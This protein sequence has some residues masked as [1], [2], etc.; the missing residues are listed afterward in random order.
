M[1]FTYS[2]R[3]MSLPLRRPP[4]ETG[5]VRDPARSKEISDET[6]LVFAKDHPGPGADVVVLIPAFNEEDAVADVVKSVPDTICGLSVETVVVDDGSRDNTTAEAEGAGALVCRLPINLGQ[7]TA[8]R[9][10]YRVSRER[11]ARF[12]CTA[13]ADGQFDPQELPA[14]VGPILA[15]QADFVNGS[16]KLGMTHNTDPV[17]NL[18]VVVFANLL[19]VLTGTKI[20]DP[21]NGLRAMRS[22]VTAKVQL[23]QTQYQTSEMLI[24]VIAHG[25]TVKEVPATMYKRAAGESKKGGNLIYGLRFARVVLTTWWKLRPVAKQ[26]LPAHQ[27]LW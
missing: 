1:A 2:F 18:G 27:G 13:D 11:G 12:I 5:A 17:R 25:F 23:K 6:A 4:L 10:G 8:F 26:N 22:E 19:S 20:T 16:R 3:L 24:N 14:L 21:A 9:L 7:G 15:G